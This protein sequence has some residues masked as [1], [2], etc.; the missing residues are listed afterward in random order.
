MQ[1]AGCYVL[2][3]RG[4]DI[5]M[6]GLISNKKQKHTGWF[7]KLPPP[8]FSTGMKKM[9]KSQLELLCH[10]VFHLRESLVGSLAFFHFGT[11]QGGTC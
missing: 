2:D 5:A 9:P 6:L 1:V 4:R 8:L 3:K 11:E 10:E 7:F